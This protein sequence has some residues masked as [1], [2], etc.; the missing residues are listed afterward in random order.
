MCVIQVLVV[1]DV[2]IGKARNYRL[3]EEVRNLPLS[4]YFIYRN[5]IIH[6][7]KLLI[8]TIYPLKPSNKV[9]CSLWVFWQDN[10]IF[11]D[12]EVKFPCLSALIEHYYGNPLPHHGSL[13]LQKPYTK[14]LTTWLTR[15]QNYKQNRRVPKQKTGGSPGTSCRWNPCL[16]TTHG[17]NTRPH[18]L[19]NCHNILKLIVPLTVPWKRHMITCSY[20]LQLHQNAPWRF[21]KTNKDWNFSKLTNNFNHI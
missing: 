14:I 3:F 19:N 9:S 16:S 20:Q 1:W 13:C 4:V 18:W 8:M 2:S 21:I 17:G 7:W 11:L 12:S 10:C 15:S 6:V 5:I